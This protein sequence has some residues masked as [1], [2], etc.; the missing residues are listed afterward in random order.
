MVLT[1]FELQAELENISSGSVMAVNWFPF[2]PAGRDVSRCD[3]KL[4]RVIYGTISSRRF[5]LSAAGT[6]KLV[7]EGDIWGL[8]RQVSQAGIS[9][10]IPQFTVGCSYLS[11]P[12]IPASGTNVLIWMTLSVCLSDCPSVSVTPCCHNM[13]CFLNYWPFVRRIQPRPVN[14]P[15]TMWSFD[16]FFDSCIKKFA[17]W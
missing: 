9:N 5:W 13:E 7:L 8:M 2:P 3:R 10:Y 15:H 17:F 4:P 1:N 14:S 6:E 16:V 12:E 11:L